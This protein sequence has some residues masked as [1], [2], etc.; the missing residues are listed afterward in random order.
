MTNI[1][2]TFQRPSRVSHGVM[3]R[4]VKG[5]TFSLSHTRRSARYGPGVLTWEGREW[6]RSYT[7]LGS[8]THAFSNGMYTHKRRRRYV[9]ETTM[10]TDHVQVNVGR[11]ARLRSPEE[12]PVYA[13]F[14]DQEMTLTG[15]TCFA[16]QNRMYPYLWIYLKYEKA[17]VWLKDYEVLGSAG[18]VKRS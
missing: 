3:Y 1:L 7:G 14:I 8:T 13:C 9:A 11:A 15:N 5:R 12:I 16:A 18:S 6:T 17:T 4:S 10:G 2:T